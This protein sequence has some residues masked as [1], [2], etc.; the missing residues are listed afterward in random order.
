MDQ[1]I[2]DVTAAV[3][4]RDG[5]ALIARRGPKSHLSGKWEFPGGKFDPVLDK[6]LPDC[7]RRE[8]GEELTV[9][10]E[11]GEPFPP[12]ICE[13]ESGITIRLHAFL[14]EIVE[15]EPVLREHSD[16]QWVSREELPRYRFALAD[17]PIVEW[18][19]REG[20]PAAA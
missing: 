19:F 1:P 14:C 3:I 16:L 12:V 13:L 5:R 20:I 6:D 10:V 15:G 9:T 7:L 11:V 2:I 18:L 8:I 17:I 4:C